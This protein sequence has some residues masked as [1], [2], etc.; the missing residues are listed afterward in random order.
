MVSKGAG[1]G[2]M[3]LEVAGGLGGLGMTLGKLGLLGAAGAAGYYGATALGAG[4]LGSWIGGKL[5]D[6]FLPDPMAGTNTVAPRRASP[7]QA[8]MAVH[9]DGRKVGEIVS[10]HQARAAGMPQTGGSGFDGRMHMTPLGGGAY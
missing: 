1:L 8:P 3:L 10:G 6:L 5:A 7:A 9:M 4:R 2:S